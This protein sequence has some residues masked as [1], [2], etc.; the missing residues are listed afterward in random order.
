MTVDVVYCKST[1]QINDF[2]QVPFSLHQEDEHWIPPLKLTSKRILNKKNPFFAQAELSLWIAYRGKKPVGRIAGIIN[3]AHNQ[4]YSEKIAFWGFFEASNSEEI[5][6]CLFK[7]LETWA[8][9]KGMTNLRGPMNP[10]INYECGMQISAFDTQ[11]FIMMP[12]N[13]EFYPKLVE[14]Q[15]YTK[16]IDLQAWMVNMHE[17]Y[18]D[19]KKIQIV[20]ALQKKYNI[21][22][23]RFNMKQFDKDLELIASIYNDAWQDNWGYIPLNLSEFKYL[24]ADLKSLIMPNYIYIAEMNGEPCGF[25]V[26]LPDLNQ[27]FKN[28]RNGRLFPLN[29]I[30]LLWHIKVRK[31][32]NQ[33]RIAM[34]GVLKKF[35][36]LPVGA[37]LYYEYLV[38]TKGSICLRGE[39]S[40]ILEN[41]LSMQAGL[42]LIHAHHYKSYRIYEKNIQIG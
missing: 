26:A 27:V 5:A 14:K 37:M 39:L 20:K 25:S 28:I 42:K 2:L 30:K 22:I 36:H 34:L 35:Q 32:I 7:T 41:N 40:W 17:A 12:Q 13:P 24:A 11:P 1:T 9:Q 29:F 33:G 10:S 18:M 23:R 16:L 38:Q 4:F 3:Q 15:G 19:T 6:A 8:L 21:T 31:S